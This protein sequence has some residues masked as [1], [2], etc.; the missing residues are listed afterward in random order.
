MKNRWIGTRHRP[1]PPL[2]PLW[3]S[4]ELAK[5]LVG[6]LTAITL[7][8]LGF[9]V[10]SN[11]READEARATAQRRAESTQRDLEAERTRISARQAA[12]SSLS[13]FIYERRVHSELLLSGLM[14]HA[15]SPTTISLAEVVERKKLYDAAYVNWNTNHQANLLLIRQVLDSPFYSRFEALLEFRLV[16]QVFSP[17]DRCLTEA[18]DLSVRGQD[19]RALLETCKATSLVQRSLDCGYAMTD[20]LFRLSSPTEEAAAQSILESRCPAD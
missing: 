1:P 15:K 6:T 14:R 9:L 11:F 8:V 4:L 5:L 20:E 10:N 19:P 7:A 13:R 17:L 16:S 2:K 18:Y 12:V 3:N